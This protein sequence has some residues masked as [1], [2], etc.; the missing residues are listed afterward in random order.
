MAS[1]LQ[2]IVTA[3][4]LIL[5]AAPPA[6][7]GGEQQKKQY[8]A[9]ESMVPESADALYVEDTPLT[10]VTAV[11]NYDNG[12]M[13]PDG[14]GGMLWRQ[15]GVNPDLTAIDNAREVKLKVRELADQLLCDLDLGVFKRSDVLTVSFVDQDDFSQSSAFGR[16]IAEALIYE[17]NQRG[18][19]VKEYRIG[20]EIR[21]HQ[22]EGDFMLTRNHRT[23]VKNRQAIC[24]VGTY[25]QVRG[26]VFVNARMVRVSDRSVVRTAQLVFQQTDVVRRML[27]DTGPKLD[28]GFVSMRDFETMTRAND[29][30]AIDLGEDLH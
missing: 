5:V 24:I 2:W 25:Y 8:G 12:V 7:A 22:A 15:G 14:T 9:V 23:Y 19:P 16:Y 28:S 26:S 13:L 3:L 10:P 27:A 21:G 1:A 11:G 4:L 20:N 29:L 30:T 6:W 18:V 17:L